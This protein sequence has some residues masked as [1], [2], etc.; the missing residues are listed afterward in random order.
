[1]EAADLEREL[2]EH[3]C[4][5]APALLDEPAEAVYSSHVP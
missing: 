1:V 3:V 2:L 5:L 4:A